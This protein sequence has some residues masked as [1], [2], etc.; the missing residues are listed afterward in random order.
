MTLYWLSYSKW[1]WKVFVLD[2]IM[3]CWPVSCSMSVHIDTRP[4]SSYFGTIIINF[5]TLTQS[6]CCYSPSDYISQIFFHTWGSLRIRLWL[7][8]MF[9][10]VRLEQEIVRTRG[11]VQ[12]R[13]C[14]TNEKRSSLCVWRELWRYVSL[15]MKRKWN[16]RVRK[17]KANEDVWHNEPSIVELRCG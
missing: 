8:Y 6:L 10:S 12:G 2:S 3:R 9:H 14:Y 11:W 7:W 17:K 4:K 16:L 15:K 5:H 13:C 1:W